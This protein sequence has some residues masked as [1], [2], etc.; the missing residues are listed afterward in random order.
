MGTEAKIAKRAQRANTDGNRPS[1]LK[2]LLLM[3]M[4]SYLDH[5]HINIKTQKEV[6]GL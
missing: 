2:G 3:M 6:S 5:M 4:I 1:N